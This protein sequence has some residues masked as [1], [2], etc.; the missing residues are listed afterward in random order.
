MVFSQKVLTLKHFWKQFTE[1]IVLLLGFNL[2]TDPAR[3]EPSQIFN[4][5]VRIL[6]TTLRLDLIKLW[7]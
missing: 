7:P 1:R 6:R 4:D 5:P 2:I 3:G